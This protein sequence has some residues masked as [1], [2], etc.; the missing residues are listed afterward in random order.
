M[1][2]VGGYVDK[3]IS[4]D[5]G[6]RNKLDGGD[7]H[8]G[9]KSIAVIS[10]SDNR[11]E[12]GREFGK[13]STWIKWAEPTAE[14]IRQACLAKESRVSHSEPELPQIY[15]KS[16]DVTNSRFLAAFNINLNRQ[17]NAL[18]GGRGTGKSTILEYLRWG[19]CD[20]TI[21]SSDREEMTIIDK[22]RTALIQKTLTDMGVSDTFWV[23]ALYYW[24][25]RS[26]P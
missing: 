2:C 21:Q 9:N 8:Y 23:N 5:T 11:Y 1:P 4:T 20:Q 16:I 18:I 6:Y 12:D 15:I 19:L 3:A 13:H 10:T 14:A 17:Y 7:V 26:F 24:T 22:R 25:Y